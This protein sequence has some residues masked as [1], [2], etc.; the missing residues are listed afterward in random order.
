MVQRSSW[1]CKPLILILKLAAWRAQSLCFRMKSCQL[2]EM[3]RGWTGSLSPLR[4]KSS[5]KRNSLYSL[6]TYP[7]TTAPKHPHGLKEEAVSI[8][9]VPAPFPKLHQHLHFAQVGSAGA[10]AALQLE[11]LPCN[12]SPVEAVMLTYEV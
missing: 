10:A 9:A 4:H 3:S 8:K 7:A 5:S 12:S 11:A 1:H 6:Q 2:Q